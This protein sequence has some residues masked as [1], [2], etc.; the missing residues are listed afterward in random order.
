MNSIPEIRS[1]PI[2]TDE[3]TG[4][5]FAVFALRGADKSP[6]GIGSDAYEKLH[7]D[8][9]VRTKNMLHVNELE[10]HEVLTSL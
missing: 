1:I 7:E 5:E 10:A 3:E 4:L 2:P 6:D 8:V 9:F